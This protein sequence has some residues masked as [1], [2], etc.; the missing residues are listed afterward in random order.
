MRTIIFFIGALSDIFGAF[1]QDLGSTT[2]SANP[3]NSPESN[4]LSSQPS[5]PSNLSAKTCKSPLLQNNNLLQGPQGLDNPINVTNI[6]YCNKLLEK[7][8][9]C[10][11]ESVINSFGPQLQNILADIKTKSETRDKI[12]EKSRKSLM[13]MMDALLEID[14]RL[15]TSENDLKNILGSDYNISKLVDSQLSN[16]TTARLLSIEVINY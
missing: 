14:E 6:T 4:N 5:N 12:I 16:T 7:N 3:P 9:S 8:M 13:N 1:S 10:C 11:A 15:Y 2:N